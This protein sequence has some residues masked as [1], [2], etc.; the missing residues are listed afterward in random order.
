[1][2]TDKG[3]HS[4]A[5]LQAMSAAGVRSYVPAPKQQQNRSGKP[6]EKAVYLANQRA[7]LAV[8]SLA[9]QGDLSAGHFSQL[10]RS[11][12]FVM[13]VI[14]LAGVLAAVTS[15][16]RRERPSMLPILG[17]VANMVLVG[18]FWHFRFYALGF[19]QDT[20]APR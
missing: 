19:D 20:W 18:L 11:A 7:V 6:V 5:S 8:Q 17:L 16:I 14:I 10:A 15:L 13:L 4:D 12:V 3:Y 9:T 2:V 1:M